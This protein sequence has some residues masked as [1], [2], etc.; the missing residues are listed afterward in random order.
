MDIS[1]LG[2]VLADSCT[3]GSFEPHCTFI[4]VQFFFFNLISINSV[5]KYKNESKG[6]LATYNT[7]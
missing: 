2:A 7:V 5:K 3:V 6:L 4:W 1:L